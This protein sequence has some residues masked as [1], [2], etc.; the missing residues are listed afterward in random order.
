MDGLDIRYTFVTDI[1]YLRE[2]I[3]HP[4]VLKWFPV[5]TEKEVEDAIQCWIGFCRW[6]CSLTATINHTPCAIGTLFPNSRL[7]AGAAIEILE[8]LFDLFCRESN[9]NTATTC[10]A[11]AQLV[12][13]RKHAAATWLT[14]TTLLACDKKGRVVPVKPQL[15]R[16]VLHGDI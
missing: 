12:E 8:L 16:H 9:C 1:S 3:N 5:S 2:W 6:S 4:A 10:V 11:K 15:Q 13:I 7:H 14:G